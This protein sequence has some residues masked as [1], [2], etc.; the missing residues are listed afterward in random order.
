M[1]KHHRGFTLVEAL[2]VMG[3]LAIM[4]SMGMPWFISITKSSVMTSNVNG[5]LAD[6]RFARSESL[7]RGGG[8]VMC[9]SNAPE[10]TVP[11]CNGTTPISAGATTNGWQ[12]GWV[13]FHDLNRDNQYQQGE[14]ILRVQSTITSID[15]MVATSGVSATLAYK[16]PFSATGRLQLPFATTVQFGSNVNFK[17]ELQR[18]VCVD[19]A[20]R[21]RV[22]DPASGGNASCS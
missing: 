5:F 20:G 7:R 11:V 8:V 18:V 13:I 1:K 4:V 15:S 17:N 3:I 16:F 6:L 19:V 14:P 9:R 21:G 2:V 22:A 10:A 12:T